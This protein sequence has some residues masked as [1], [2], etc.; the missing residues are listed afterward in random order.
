MGAA[1]GEARRGSSSRGALVIRLFS[2]ES[3]GPVSV[4]Q[5]AL[6]V[7]VVIEACAS[8]AFPR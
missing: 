1:T 4:L 8:L 5:V 3:I 6:G 7:Q 2:A